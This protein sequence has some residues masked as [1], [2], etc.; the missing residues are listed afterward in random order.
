[1]A[2]FA[3][4][5][6][7]VKRRVIDLPATVQAEVPTLINEAMKELERKHNFRVME[8]LG[9]YYSTTVGSNTLASIPDNFKDF[10][11]LPFYTEYNGTSR[12]ITVAA[13]L[14]AVLDAYSNTTTGAP[15]V[16]RTT[17]PSDTGAASWEIYPLP[18][19][20]SDW[21]GGEYRVYVPYWRY[22]PLLS[23][24]TDTNW[25]TVN[26]E[27][28][29]VYR[30]TSEAFALDWDEN[31]MT[32][33]LQKAVVVQNEIIQ[34]DKKQILSSVKTLVPLWQGVNQPNLRY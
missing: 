15:R 25:F 19:G 18:N 14:Q 12:D 11:G 31:R 29:L 20:F 10:R 13:N 23:A 5:Q 7:R 8:T 9:G 16:L 24:D 32:L 17:E 6:T 30:A 27:E 21:T 3:E 4:I 22:F 2:T 26:A 1:M 34:T 28:W 33:W